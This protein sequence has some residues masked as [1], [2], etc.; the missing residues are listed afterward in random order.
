MTPQDLAQHLQEQSFCICN[1]FF[2][3]SLVQRMRADFE[4]LYSLG[5]FK[6]AAT[7]LGA[8]KEVRDDIRRDEILWLEPGQGNATQDL[9]FAQL[10]TLKQA[11]NRRL[12][13]GLKSFEGHYASYPRGGFYKK[14]LDCFRNNNDRVV[15]LIIYLNQQWQ[16]ADGGQLRLYTNNG[17]IDV[18]PTNGTMVCF[19]SAE[20]EH[21]VLP[22][23]APR[24]SFTGWFKS[25]G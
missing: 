22:S 20:I 18:N 16:E 17:L 10:D 14:H 25:G 23:H 24:A 19:L 4:H 21:E 3:A 1:E 8:E 12:F 13:L 6:R 7:G 9:L 2:D 11:F 5:E 15:S